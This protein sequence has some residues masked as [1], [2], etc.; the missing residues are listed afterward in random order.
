MTTLAP[1]PY[2][3]VELNAGGICERLGDLH[4]TYCAAFGGP[5][6]CEAETQRTDFLLRVLAHAHAP[7]FR[8][9]LGRE[10]STGRLVGFA[11]G[12]STLDPARDPWASPLHEALGPQFSSWFL[13]GAFQLA[14]LAVWPTM[15]R[16]GIGGALHDALLGGLTQQR[17]WLL[18]SPRADGAVALFRGRGW[19]P[20]G[21]VGSPHHDRERTVMSIA[22]P[23]GVGAGDPH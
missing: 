17:A 23:A 12:L 15:R 8:C 1:S 18:T 19:C 6:W 20:V 16:R 2:S 21:S 5:P 4:L 3:I 11:Y 10:M 22:L 7:G 9:F 14:E 13:A